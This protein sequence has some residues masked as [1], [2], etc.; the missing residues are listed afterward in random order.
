MLFATTDS[1]AITQTTLFTERLQFTP[2]VQ[3]RR[4]II[5]CHNVTIGNQSSEPKYH[6]LYFVWIDGNNLDKAT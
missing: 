4:V 5:K 3:F 2:K 1:I 6:I